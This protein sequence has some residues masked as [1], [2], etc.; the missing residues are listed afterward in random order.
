V[1]TLP[2]APTGL[3]V[4]DAAT[5]TGVEGTGSFD[6]LMKF[7]NSNAGGAVMAGAPGA[8][9]QGVGGMMQGAGSAKAAEANYQMQ[10]QQLALQRAQWERGNSSASIRF[11]H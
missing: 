10:Q 11:N 2:T 9:M 7:F 1:P 6:G 3:G 5:K 8:I 4:S